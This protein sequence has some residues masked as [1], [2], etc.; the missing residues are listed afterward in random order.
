MS[1][2]VICT[3]TEPVYDTAT[4]R[5]LLIPQGSRIFDRYNSQ[6]SYGQSRLQVVWHWII[7]RDTSSLTLD[8]L[9]GTDPAGY[10]GLEDVVDRHWN[11]LLVGAALTTLFRRGS[12]TGRAGE[13]PGRQPHRH[14]WP[15][16]AAGL[17]EL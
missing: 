13:P 1:G 4:G 8:N 7:L 12:R 10:A 15:E 16:W 5:H 2:D 9:V 6:V 14:R 3:V 11:R 17:C